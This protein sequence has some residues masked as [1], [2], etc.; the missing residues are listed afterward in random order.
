MS[1]QWKFVEGERVCRRKDIYNNKSELI[2][3][4]VISRVRTLERG[5]EYKVRWDGENTTKT[6]FPHGLMRDSDPR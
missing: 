1:T 6:Y 5:E 2:K 3:G 4:E